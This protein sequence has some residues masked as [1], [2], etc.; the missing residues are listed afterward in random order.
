[1]PTMAIFFIPGMTLP[2][3]GVLV[4]IYIAGLKAFPQILKKRF[5]FKLL[6]NPV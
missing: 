3:G 1:M 5:K 4:L 2:P 6:W